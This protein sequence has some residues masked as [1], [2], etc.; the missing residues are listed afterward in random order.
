MRWTGPCR[1]RLHTALLLQGGQEQEPQ[2]TGPEPQPEPKP[3]AHQ[4]QY[5]PR[6]RRR[7]S[8]AA[9]PRTACLCPRPAPHRPAPAHGLNASRNGSAACGRGPAPAP[10]PFPHLPPRVSCRACWVCLSLAL[11]ADGRCAPRFDPCMPPL[12]QLPARTAFCVKAAQCS[13]FQ[14]ALMRAPGSCGCGLDAHTPAGLPPSSAANPA[15]SPP[16]S[17]L[18]KNP[19]APCCPPCRHPL[20]Q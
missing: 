6:R 2:P 16:S 14:A 20:P 9:P 11:Q 18:T 4:E 19:V 13:A 3:R 17:A 5:V 10:P 7:C 12:C 8:P 1:A 15:S